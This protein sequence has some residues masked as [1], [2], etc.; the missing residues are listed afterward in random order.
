MRKQH[1]RSILIFLIVLLLVL[2]ATIPPTAQPVQAEDASE[3]QGPIVDPELTAK[4]NRSESVGYM[5]YFDAEADLSAAY[6]LSWEERG[7]Y[8]VETLTTLAEETQQ[9]VRSYL[10]EQGVAYQAFWIDNAIA[11]ES[12]T[13]AAFDGLLSFSEIHSLT[14]I[15][16]IQLE[17]P[18]STEIEEEEPGTRSVEDNLTHIN[19]DDVWMLGYTGAN[20]VVGSIDT[21]VN[22]SHEALIE[23]Y[24]GNQGDGTIDHNYSWWDAIN[25]RSVAYD[26]HSHGS[27]TVGIMVGDDGD[28]DQIGVAPGAEW[29]ACKAFSSSG[30]ATDTSLLT[31]GQFMLAPTR[32]DGSDADPDMRPHVV[33]NSWGDC[34]Q[35]FNDWYQD[36]IDAWL[37]AGIYP[38]FSAGNAGNC[39]YSYPP[40]LNTVGNPARASNVTAVGSTGNN[41]GQYATHSNWGP[42]DTTDTLN[43]G[44]YTDMKPQVVAPGVSIRSAIG[45]SYGTAGYGYMTGT[46]MSA[47]HV[48]GLIA[49]MWESAT[50]LVGDYANTETILQDSA[51]PIYYDDGIE[52]GARWPNYA[53]GW[54]EINAK[55]AVDQAI[56]YCGDGFLDGVVR[57]ASS[58][59]I[60]GATVEAAAQGTSENDRWGKTDDDGYYK[61]AANGDETYDLTADAYGYQSAIETGVALSSGGTA[62]KDFSLNEEG[63][64]AVSGTILDGS[65]HGYPLYAF[66][67]FH[68]ELNHEELFTNPFDGTY[69]LELFQDTA[70]DLTLISLIEGYEEKSVTGLSF[71]GLT[72][73]SDQTL[74]VNPVCFAPGYTIVDGIYEEFEEGT[75]PDGWSLINNAG[76]DAVWRFD[77]PGERSNLTGGSG[78]F[79][80]IDSDYFSYT[81]VDTA[82]VSPSVD[83][84]DETGTFIAFD[85]DFYYYNGEPGEVADVDVSIAGGDWQT[86]FSQTDNS[87][88]PD[89]VEIDISGY[90]DDQSD[91][92]VRF[93]YYNAD[94]EWWWQVDNVQVG[95]Y[96]CVVT[97]GGVLAGF[98][99]DSDT[100]DPINGALVYSSSV[101]TE[102]Q[103]MPDDPALDDG[104]Y[105]LFQPMES[106]PQTLSFTGGGGV[107]VNELVDL[108]LTQDDATRYDFILETLRIFLSI[109]RR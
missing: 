4:F 72:G 63:N 91:V 62:S 56:A 103:S 26:D 33:N 35:S 85:Q 54:G 16:E 71:S 43:G 101:N 1:I 19:A 53:T 75:L 13:R 88:G 105:W 65:G 39:G 76:T 79:A 24:R 6:A 102:S 14:V 15:H 100:G 106:N 73:T 74:E 36:T 82:L 89:H 5:I 66:L 95:P 34:D 61:I 41:D 17:E 30:G 64:V 18:V 28:D 3:E 52:E 51:V 11:V 94:Y 59:P 84:S 96:D 108:E 81:S 99:T 97:P 87:R 55:A 42:T 60:A 68:S 48:T 44:S 7:D 69:S 107:Y 58:Q 38:V 93:H 20:I 98:V 77:N 49:L 70:Y 25:G 10:D 47:P 12:S 67:I 92:R 50:C 29:I 31:C 104:F 86:V 40:G 78:G 57:D 109:F 37:A 8:V 45:D 22:Y 83:L 27:H 23:Q 32:L 2:T 9:N 80:I 21:G 46:S 90:A